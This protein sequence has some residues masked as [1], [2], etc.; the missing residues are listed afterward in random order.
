VGLLFAIN[1]KLVQHPTGF[2]DQA[3]Y[4]ALSIGGCITYQSAVSKKVYETGFIYDLIGFDKGFNDFIGVIPL[5]ADMSAKDLRF[6][7]NENGYF[8]Q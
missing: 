8:A 3:G 4:L 1:P 2:S 7:R 6:D 5:G